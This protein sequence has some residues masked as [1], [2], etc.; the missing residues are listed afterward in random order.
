MVKG[1]RAA[2]SQSTIYFLPFTSSDTGCL[3]SG[4]REYEVLIRKLELL[5]CVDQRAHP[6]DCDADQ[7]A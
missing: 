2:L 3:H 6:A 4:T 7:V 1:K 5:N